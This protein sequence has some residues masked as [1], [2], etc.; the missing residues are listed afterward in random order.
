MRKD[1]S[2][3]EAPIS[4]SR[5]QADAEQ[6]SYLISGEPTRSSTVL[7]FCRP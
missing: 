5:A 1:G 2:L 6:L 3:L 7:S 4:G